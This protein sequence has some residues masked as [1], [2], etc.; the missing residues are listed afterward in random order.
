MQVWFQKE[1]ELIQKLKDKWKRFLE[2]EI[3]IMLKYKTQLLRFQ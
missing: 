3:L 1:K 2:T